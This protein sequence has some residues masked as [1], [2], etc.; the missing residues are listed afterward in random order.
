MKI[1]HAII[2]VSFLAL[3]ACGGKKDGGNAEEYNANSSKAEATQVDEIARGE[4]LVK[5]NDCSTCHHKINTLIGPS[6]TDVAKKYEFTEANVKYL[7]EKIM[8]G[9]SGA[10]G[11]IPMAAHVDISEADAQAMARYVL[12]MDGE[13]EH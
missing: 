5:G 8:K 1:K 13:K 4:V 3:T 10:W 9:G 7:A 12:S 6:H 2:I 11:Q